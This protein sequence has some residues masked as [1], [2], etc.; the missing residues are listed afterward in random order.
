M[1]DSL[2]DRYAELLTGSY[3]CV[4]RIVLNAFFRMGHG[5][6]GFRVW[7]RALTGSE[8][9][10][11]NTHLMRMAGRF[12]R[13]IH[14]Y[15]KANGIPVVHCPAGERKHELAEEY[16]ARTNI[17]QGLFL[18]LVGRAQAPV[19]DV[20][21]NHHI[22]PKKP[23]PYVNHYSFHILDPEWGHIT[24]KISGHPPFPAQVIL[25]GHEYVACQARK[26]GIS[27]TKE[28][29]CF[30]QISDAAGLAK[31]ADTL[32][33]QQAIGRLNQACERWIY[34]T[35]LCFALELE[36]Q[37]RSGF[38]YQYSNYQVEYSRN[39]IFEIGGHMDQV[40]Q[41]LIDRS[42]VPLDLET[43]KTILGYQ[44]RPR[45]RQRKSKSAQWEVAVEKATYDLT[46]LKLHCGKLTLK[47]Y[48][49]GER[50]LRIEV[51]VHNTQE[52][53][54]GRSLEKFPRIVVQAKEILERFMNALSCIDQCFIADSMLEE[55][56]TPSRVG[57]TKVG[58][59][60]LNKPRMRWVVEAVI[61]LCLSLSPHGFT[62]SELARQVRVLSNQGESEYGARRAAYDLKKL[63]GKEI[64][65]RIG[66]TRR[67][68]S[69]SSGLKAMVA[70]VVLRNKA[71]KPLLAAAQDLRPSRGAQNPRPLD[72]NYEII[73]TAMQVVFQELG[74]AA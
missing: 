53:Q 70:L 39:L 31:I 69:T 35:C 73:R 57:T 32:S 21:V 56:P 54:C 51:V 59:I 2:S 19:W 1:P 41:A 60:D 20:S 26:A 24:I 15:A 5:P 55:L 4:D 50:V 13:R 47:I 58:G 6:G 14:G 10:L 28:G 22:E 63:R 45:Y 61:A 29:N 30:T 38:R 16:L 66:Q 12:S 64:V 49:K 68:Q 62:A 8:E 37:K 34:T 48:T 71:I 40:F 44:R 65:R 27:F 3:D 33:G 42:R 25:N 9:T 72:R 36:E 43:I 67:Y 7:W 11:D 52:L 17:T 74:L 18:I 23:M 46:I